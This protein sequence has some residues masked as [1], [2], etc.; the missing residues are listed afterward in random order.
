VLQVPEQACAA[1]GHDDE[2]QQ[3]QGDDASAV[4]R[5]VARLLLLA[6]VLRVRRLGLDDELAQ[7]SV[8]TMVCSPMILPASICARTSR[9]L[10]GPKSSL[11]F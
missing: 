8:S 5:A 3:Q 2:E 10:N 6:L 9:K 4:P 1:A 11:S 7:L